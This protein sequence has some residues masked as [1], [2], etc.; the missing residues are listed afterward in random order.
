MPNGVVVAGIFMVASILLWGTSY[1]MRGR[2]TIKRWSREFKFHSGDTPIQ[3]S[4]GISRIPSPW[5]LRHGIFQLKQHSKVASGVVL[6]KSE[7]VVEQKP[8]KAVMGATE[9]TMM[10]PWKRMDSMM[11]T[12][13]WMLWNGA[14]RLLR[15]EWRQGC[16]WW[17]Q[18]LS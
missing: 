17:G 12:G 7:S 2:A 14:M 8:E 1:Y 10:V 13:T 6:T 5:S 3:S 9:V 15:T 18:P 16:F 11:P 4:R